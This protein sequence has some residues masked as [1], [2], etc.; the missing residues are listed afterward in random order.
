MKI[1]NK[2][3]V[4]FSNRYKRPDI[5]LAL[6]SLYDTLHE[7]VLAGSLDFEDFNCLVKSL[8]AGIFDNKG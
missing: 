7:M 8:Q 6:L 3:F 1:W 2:L 5:P 4:T